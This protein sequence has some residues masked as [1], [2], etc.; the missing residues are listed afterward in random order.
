M[1]DHK[2]PCHP[3][4]SVDYDTLVG[5]LNAA[6]ADGVV[7]ERQDGNLSL[8]CYTTRAVYDEVWN[9]FTSVARGLILD[10][11]DRRI[12]A[13]PFPKFYNLGEGGRTAPS[14][15]FEAFE[16]LDGSLIIAFHHDGAWRTATK[17]DFNS[18]QAKAAMSM[19]PFDHMTPGPTHLFELI[20]PS[21]KI[22][23]KY[24][25]DECRLQHLRH[26]WTRVEPMR[27]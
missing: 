26:E 19:L 20:G 10:R 4:H 1:T 23:V 6:I 21:N 15:S 18:T 27:S 9:L 14:E 25:K 24:P 13:T 17:G 11:A 3:A 7:Y 12:V 16:K 8:F 22:V 2:L 5:G